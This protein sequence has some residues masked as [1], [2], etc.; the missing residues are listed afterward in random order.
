MLQKNFKKIKNCKFVDNIKEN[1]KNSDLV[2]LHTEWDEFKSLEFKKIIKKRNFS[3]Y[4]LRNLY[5][6]KEMK[7]E[8]IKYFSI[9]RPLTD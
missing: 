6:L 5:S 9:G 2:I 4:D 8:N 7:R 3:V 1:C